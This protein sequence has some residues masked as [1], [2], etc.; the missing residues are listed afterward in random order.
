MS[1]YS[2]GEIEQRIEPRTKITALIRI[3]LRRPN[4]LEGIPLISVPITAPHSRALTTVSS[5]STDSLNA[6]FT[7]GSAPEMTPMSN[8]NS[9]PASAAVKPMK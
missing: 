7:K 3:V 9:R 2:D 4:L 1:R 8:P 5:D 6:F